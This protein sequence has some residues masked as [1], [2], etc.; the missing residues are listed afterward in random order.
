MK[1]SLI[2]K[3]PSWSRQQEIH[4]DLFSDVGDMSEAALVFVKECALE[5]VRERGVFSVALSGGKTPWPLYD[6]LK[7]ESGF[8]WEKT[9]VF[10]GDER[11]VPFD[12]VMSNYG[13]AK[14]RL[15]SHV[16]IPQPNIHPMSINSLNLAQ[17]AHDSEVL[18]KEAFQRI[19]PT[20]NHADPL[21]PIP[22][23]DLILLGM[24]RDGHVASLFP[25][26]PVLFEAHRF[27]AWMDRGSMAPF[28]PRLTLTL[29]VITQ[30][31]TILF[32][33]SGKEKHP[34]LRQV[35]NCPSGFNVPASLVFSRERLYWF[36]EPH[37]EN[38]LLGTE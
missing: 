1:T 22:E 7:R 20:H 17:A 23:F 21:N 34:V 27:V 29:P 31:R 10:F 18:L 12:S 11:F 30:A 26:S 37:F 9:H 5:S 2:L 28:V 3:N 14:D 8:P 4:L 16:A 15:L 25:H 19:A 35:L 24:G 36:V 38:R 6:L 33:V 13:Q 32:L